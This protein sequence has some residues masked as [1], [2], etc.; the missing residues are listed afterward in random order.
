MTTD[1]EWFTVSTAQSVAIEFDVAGLGDRFVAALIDYAVLGAVGFALLLGINEVQASVWRRTLGL[2]GSL[3]LLV[4]FPTCE[5]IF[6]GRTLGK[7]ARGLRVMRT[8][9]AEPTL[10]DLLLRWVLRPIDLWATSGLAAVGTV[11][12]TGTGQRLG[13]LAAGTTVIDTRSRTTLDDTLFASVD[14]DYEPT[15]AATQTLDR[16]DVQTTRQVLQRLQDDASS[17]ENIRRLAERT[18]TALLRK[19]DTTTDLHTE[20]FLKTVL[21]DYNYYQR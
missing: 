19:L 8:G 9:G 14:A 12:Y 17:N 11:L 10:G 5:L 7:W 6:N 15:F 13:D 21:R 3:P 1:R 4:Y 18:R 20:Q 2:L 16:D